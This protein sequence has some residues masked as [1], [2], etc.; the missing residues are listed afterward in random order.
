MEKFRYEIKNTVGI[1]TNSAGQLA[2]EAGEF[3]CR[4]TLR[5]EDKM[6]DLTK[7]TSIMGLGVKCGD[8]VTVT[9]EGADEVAAA[10]SL[11][12][13]FNQNL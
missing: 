3:E 4:T 5:K 2:R 13:F 8:V 12:A 7:D 9:T 10:T 6:A 11:A 1:H